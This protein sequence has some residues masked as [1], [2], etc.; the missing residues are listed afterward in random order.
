MDESIGPNPDGLC[1]CGC[2]ERTARAPQTKRSKG[3]MKGKHVR[4]L[5][6]HHQRTRPRRIT[7]ADYTVEDRGYETPCWIWR[8]AMNWFGYGAVSVGGRQRNA[9]AAMYEQE[10]GPIGEGLVLDHLC[11][12]PACVR[13]SHCEPVP[14]RVNVQRGAAAKLTL[15]AAEEIRRLHATGE[16]RH[17]ALAERYGVSRST[18][19]DT[20]NGR[21]WHPDGSTRA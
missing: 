7:S 10:V 17:G 3:W 16:W 4:F 9:H 11:R 1:Q 12:V 15:A 5:P 8:H 13:P 19:T 2:G 18:I 20:V 14:Q 6:H 21:R